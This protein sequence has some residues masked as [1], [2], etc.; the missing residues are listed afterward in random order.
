MCYLHI[1]TAVMGRI[2]HFAENHTIQYILAAYA[3]LKI[4]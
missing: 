3:A 2:G 4:I 1:Q